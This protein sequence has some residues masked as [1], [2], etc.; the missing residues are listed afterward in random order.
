MLWACCVACDAAVNIIPH[1]QLFF[2]ATPNLT[3]PNLT[4][5][6]DMI[7]RSWFMC[8]MTNKVGDALYRRGSRAGEMYF[9]T[10]GTV[11]TLLLYCRTYRDPGMR[12]SFLSGVRSHGRA[13]L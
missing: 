13:L 9:I 1:S 11:S 10:S 3:Q 12:A 7:L 5:A 8:G 4:S 2:V 6:Y